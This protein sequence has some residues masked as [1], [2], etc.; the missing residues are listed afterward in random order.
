MLHVNQQLTVDI[1]NAVRQQPSVPGLVT[2]NLFTEVTNSVGI[3]YRSYEIDYIDF[4]EQRLLPHKLS[5]YGPALVSGDVDGNGLDDIIVSGTGN[6]PP[7]IL[8]QQADGKFIRKPVRMP[9]GQQMQRPESLGTLLFDADNDGALD[10]YFA[11]GSNQFPAD[12]KSYQDWFYINDGK[13]NFSFDGAGLPANYTSKSCVKAADIDG[14]SDLDLFIGGRVIP[15][16]YPLPVSSFIYRNDTQNGKIK[17]TDVTNA[18]APGLKNIGLIC[19]ALWTDF[20]NDGQTDLLLVGEWMPLQFF[21]NNRGK[22]E[23]VSAASGINDE[24]GWWNSITAGDFDN[25]GDIDYIAGNLGKNSFYRASKEHPVS[26]Y[27]KDFDKN[28][29]IDIIT[30]VYLPD[31]K[32]VLKEFPAQTREEHVDQIPSLKKKFLKYKDFGRATITDIFSNEELK[33]A[34]KLQAN[35][36]ENSYIENTG[37]GKFRMHSLPVLAQVAPFYAG[38]VEDFNHDGNLDIA[39]TGNDFGTEV[40]NGRYDALN[41]IMLLGDGTGNF[42]PLSILQSGIYIPGDGRALIRLKGANNTYLLAASQNNSTVKVFKS[43][44]SYQFYPIL[45]NDKYC[46]LTLKNG[47]KRKLELYKGESYLSQSGAS[48]IADENIVSIEIINNKNDRRKLL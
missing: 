31:E 41:G 19:D 30:T 17:F 29:G 2:G 48:V 15:G 47:K 11:N 39:F 4:N 5:Q 28:K 18:I 32:G 3:S 14:D 22:L 13:G 21:K 1:K 20:D 34:L 40:G 46:V 38:V 27:A 8:M 44:S 16:Q 23:N 10:L 9:E 7:T 12:S 35:N 42:S 6:Y 26:M 24:K 25:D 43:K 37:N 33:E 45:P 36:F